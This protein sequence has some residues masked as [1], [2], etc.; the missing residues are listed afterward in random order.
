MR[1]VA[2]FVLNESSLQRDSVPAWID[3]KEAIVVDDIN[4]TPRS[5][6]KVPTKEDNGMKVS[7]DVSP[8]STA[9]ISANTKSNV[10]IT[11][12][13]TNDGKRAAKIAKKAAKEARKRE[14]AE[15]REAKK[16]RKEAREAKK[17]EK[18]AKKRKREEQE[19]D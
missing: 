1:N 5:D 8:E 19:D 10:G 7:P 17:L 11:Q 16:A 12:N 2:N 9:A 3:Q 18:A 13:T 15:K 4:E 6:T 14:R